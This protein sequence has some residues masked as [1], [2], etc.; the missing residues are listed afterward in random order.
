[1]EFDSENSLLYIYIPFISF[2]LDCNSGG[3]IYKCKRGSYTTVGR[4]KAWDSQI[5]KN[6]FHT[7]WQQWRRF[8]ARLKDMWSVYPN[9]ASLEICSIVFSELWGDG[10]TGQVTAASSK[11]LAA[12]LQRLSAS[13]RVIIPRR[14]W[15]DEVIFGNLLVALMF[16]LPN[17]TSFGVL[18]HVKGLV[19]NW[20]QLKPI[21]L[22][23]VLFTTC[24]PSL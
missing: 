8:W 3:L 22:P 15:S 7:S 2:W 24:R 12:R 19:S 20:F 1:M 4:P 5:S 9:N 13:P 11:L 16:V 17:R 18:G 6:A 14:M 23:G 21:T 10:A